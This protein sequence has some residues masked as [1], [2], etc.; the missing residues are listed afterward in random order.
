LAICWQGKRLVVEQILDAWRS[1]DGKC[2]RIN[3]QDGQG[4]ELHYSESND[5]WSIV[6]S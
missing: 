3:T 4:F 5:A 6:Q 2:Y 1:P